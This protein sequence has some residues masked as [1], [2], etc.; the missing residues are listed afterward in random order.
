MFPPG[1][2][3]LSPGEKNVSPGVISKG[4]PVL[5]ELI[6]AIR[7]WIG[8]AV[9]DPDESTSIVSAHLTAYSTD[10]EIMSYCTLIIH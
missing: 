4:Y 10:L 6:I 7:A 2:K 9:F 1:E 5:K 8:A 3:S